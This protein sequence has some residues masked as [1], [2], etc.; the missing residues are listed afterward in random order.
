[1]AKKINYL[2]GLLIFITCISG[3]A[4]NFCYGQTKK[5][6]NPYQKIFQKGQWET[7]RI[8]G[9]DPKQ[10]TYTLTKFVQRKFAGNLTNFLNTSNFTSR[11][12]SFCGNDYFTTVSGTYHFFDSDKVKISA[13]TVTYSGEWKNKPT[14]KRKTNY[15][16]F[17]IEKKGNSYIFT[18]L[19]Q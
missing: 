1:M 13:A 19:E 8:L 10:K 4:G 3:L 11:Y 6:Q 17:K 7:D 15:I 12:T 18:K 2:H 5:V 14:E 9:L 16:I